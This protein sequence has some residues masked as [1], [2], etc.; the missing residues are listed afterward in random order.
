MSLENNL[1]SII[2]PVYN[3]EEFIMDAVMS[4]KNQTY[5][6]WELIL[7]D[8]ASEDNSPSLIKMFCDEDSRIYA[9]YLEQNGG[10]ANARNI[11]IKKATGEYLTF[12]DSDDWWFPQKLELQLNFM[13][14]NGYAFTYT[15]YIIVEKNGIPI[16]QRVVVPPKLSYEQALSQTAISTITVMIDLKQI[17]TIEMPC[18][19]YGAE[20]TG[21]WLNILKKVK[22]AYGLQKELSAYRQVPNSLSHNCK[23]RFLRNWILYRKVENLSLCDSIKN[24]IKY[25]KYVLTKRQH[26]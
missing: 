26:Y 24:Y 19:E 16:R 11:G 25:V 21:T 4:I 5:T 15:N 12:L 8:D 10:A 22:F 7:V 6:H 1:I 17:T 9:I 14:S 3:S 2:M 23:A 18:L 13:K 20:D